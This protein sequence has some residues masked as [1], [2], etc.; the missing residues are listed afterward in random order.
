M[1]L[2]YKVKCYTR[3]IWPHTHTACKSIFNRLWVYL[4]GLGKPA[5]TYG[6]AAYSVAS[7]VIISSLDYLGG[8]CTNT[9]QREKYVQICYGLILCRISAVVRHY[10]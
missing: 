4:G 9:A 8:L 7:F 5:L 2:K 1:T 6:S 3:A 10:W